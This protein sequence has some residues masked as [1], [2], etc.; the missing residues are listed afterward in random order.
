MSYYP[1]PDSHIRY[2]VKVVLDLPIYATKKELKLATDIDTSDLAAKKDFITLKGEVEKLGIDKLTNV[3]SSLNN[4]KTKVDHLD[5]GKLKTVPVDLKKL[6]DTVDNE[7][8]KNIKFNTLK[9]K[10]NN[11]DKEIPDATTLILI[12]QYNT[13][14]QNL[15]KKNWRC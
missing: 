7:V 2:K 10:A 9:S 5:P 6:S 14:K 1:E 12:N 11:L 15:E 8:V 13:D 4:L 3:S